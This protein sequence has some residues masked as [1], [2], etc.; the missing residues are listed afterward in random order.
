MIKNWNE[1]D[2]SHYKRLFEIIRKDWENELDMNLA[3]VSV[4]SDIPIEDITNMEVNKLQE[5]INNLKFIETP[6]KPKTP[7]TTYNIGN[8]EYK[9][10][11]NVNKMTASQYIDFQNFYKQY[12]D[13]MPNLAA[14]FLLPN[15]K[16]YGED[17]DPIDEAEFL[18][19]HLTIDIFSDIMF[20]FVNLLQV[21][22]LSTLHSSER[23]MKKR[24]RKTRD[25][26]ERRKLLKSLIQTRRLILLLKNEAELSE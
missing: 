21:S 2:L 24:L 26:L 19:T 12:D 25:K 7:E 4:L 23:E 16:K 8:K 10:F 17:Y 13:F 11:F 18:N 5:F 3:M 6:Y 1:M 15:G 9:V 22:T 14:C 20:F